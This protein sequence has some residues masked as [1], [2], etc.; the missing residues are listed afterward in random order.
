[1][2]RLQGNNL[3]FTPALFQSGKQD[4][5]FHPRPKPSSA[6]ASS[7]VFVDFFTHLLIGILLSASP[8]TYP[9]AVFLYGVLMAILPDFDVVLFPFWKKHPALRHHGISHSFAFVL[10]AGPVGAVP[11]A[12]LYGTDWTMFALAGILGGL[13]HVVADY[14]TS[15]AVPLWAPVSWKGHALNV[16]LPVNPYTIVT[17]SAALGVFGILWYSEGTRVLLPWALWVAGL[18]LGIYVVSRA[19]VK[20]WLRRKVPVFDPTINEFEPTANPLTWYLRTKKQ[21]AETVVT[22]YEKVSGLSPK[23]RGNVFY[24]LDRFPDTREGPLDGPEDALLRTAHAARP[25]LNEMWSPDFLAATIE[26]EGE[27]YAVFWFI[28]WRVFRS[29]TPGILARVDREG[30]VFVSETKRALSW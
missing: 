14:L 17:S 16:E 13:S 22:R 15:F 10:I 4:I 28:W 3:V 2:P 11:M 9:M 24:D 18:S 7:Q 27:G 8:A 25:L 21:F 20:R 1:M 30:Q 6:E 29:P 23:P 19:V 26:S 5:F 12:F